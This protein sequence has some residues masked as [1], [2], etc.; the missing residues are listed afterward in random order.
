MQVGIVG[1]SVTG[2]TSVFN[3]VSGGSAQV[4][5]FS[6][7]EANMAVVPVPD[8][9]QSWLSDLYKPK[10]T[11]FATVELVDVAGVQAGQAKEGGFS[12]T[13]MQNL[14]QVDALV[15][16]VRAFEN[17]A[18]PHPEGS[19]DP[20]RDAELFELE[21]II[22]DLGVVE[23]RLEKIDAEI[24]RKK[25]PEKNALEQEKELLSKFKDELTSEKPLRT[26]ELSEDEQKLI[27][28]YT[29]LS[30]KPML[31]V[32]N[33][34]ESDIGKDKIPSLEKLQTFADS[35]GIPVLT[36]CAKTEM[37]IAQLD[38]A[39]RGE[40]LTALGITESGREKLI[41]ASYQLLKLIAF[42]TVGDDEVKAWTITRGTPAQEAARKIHSDI[43]RGFIRAEVAPYESIRTLGTW[44]NAKDK[45]QVRLEGKE[46]LVADGDCINFRFAV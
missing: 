13:M 15:H 37:E 30:Q 1:L 2:K 43:A 9:R 6:G 10:K 19:I 12:P 8:E 4:G 3:A 22:A 11:T 7:S 5:G 20:F 31:I 39:D 17:P 14:R 29:F 42:F 46:Y 33:I 16:V 21:L 45:G 25:G 41:K 36:F 40:F 18:V 32:A 35:K 34:E 28:G 38:E 44:N 27:R 26:I 23:K 24:G